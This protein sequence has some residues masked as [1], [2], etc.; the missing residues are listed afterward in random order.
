MPGVTPTRYL[1]IASIPMS[2]YGAWF[3]TDLSSLLEDADQRGDDRVIPQV[4]GRA[5]YQRFRDATKHVLPMEIYGVNDASGA[6]HA[7]DPLGID[8]NSL[9]LNTNVVAPTGTGDGTRSATLHLP[10]GNR[11]ASIHVLKLSLGHKG[12]NK[13]E[14]ALE[15]SIPAGHFA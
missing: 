1:E 11:T 13:L 10:G 6:A 3:I 14:A 8:A 2:I 12:P 5:P 4:S 15:I 9:Y 7:N